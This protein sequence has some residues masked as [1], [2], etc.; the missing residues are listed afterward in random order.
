MEVIATQDQLDTATA[1]LCEQA[2]AFVPIIAQTGPLPLRRAPGGFSGV[3]K[4]IV[5]QQVSTASA[6]A[7]WNR[8]DQAGFNRPAEWE[9]APDEVLQSLGLSRPKIR[10]GRALCDAKIDWDDLERLPDRDVQSMLTAVSGIGPWTAHIYLLSCLG[11]PDV[12]PDA[13]LALQESAKLAFDLPDRP[14]ARDLADRAR[15]WSPYRSVAARALWS[16]YRIIKGKE[17]LA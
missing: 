5:G 16:Y 6:A 7:I 2:P 9:G 13:D 11:R 1:A 4:I 17:G 3:L 10:Y 15:L 8:V 14:T 12:F